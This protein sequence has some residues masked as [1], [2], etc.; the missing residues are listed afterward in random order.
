MLLGAIAVPTYPPNYYK[1]EHSLKKLQLIVHDTGST[2]CLVTKSISRLLEHYGA[3][4]NLDMRLLVINVK[5]AENDI[6]AHAITPV[7]LKSI[8][9]DNVA[10]LQ[11]TSGSTSSPKGVC[12]SHSN[13]VHQSLRFLGN[14]K[15][16]LE[17]DTIVVSLE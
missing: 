8:S 15:G 9:P 10:F 5:S 4:K 2:C 13:L 12:I 1:M 16:F 6:D 14:E 17:G 3:A 11:Y 7:L